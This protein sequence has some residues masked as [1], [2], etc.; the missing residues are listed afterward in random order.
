MLFLGVISG[1]YE[2]K[3]SIGS[4]GVGSLPIV[5]IGAIIYFHS[6]R[7]KHD[8]I[9]TKYIEAIQPLFDLGLSYTPKSKDCSN[10]RL[11]ILKT[12]EELNINDFENSM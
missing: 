10:R 9:I 11:I 6:S 8:Q 4:L 1:N 2:I 3:E 5:F 7:K 12:G